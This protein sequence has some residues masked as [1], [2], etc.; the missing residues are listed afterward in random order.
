MPPFAH[1]EIRS[2]SA[3]Q[4]LRALTLLRRLLRLDTT[5]CAAGLALL[6]V[7]LA[8]LD[9]RCASDGGSAEVTAVALLGCAVDDGLV[10]FARGGVGGEGGG[11]EVLGG[12]DRHVSKKAPEDIGRG[13]DGSTVPCFP[14]QRSWW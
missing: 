12:L 10:D 14:C 7:L 2:I 1:A 4:H 6:L 11:C 8:Q 9:S 3:E 5:R 13:V